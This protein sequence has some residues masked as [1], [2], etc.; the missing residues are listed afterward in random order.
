ML[1]QQLQGAGAVPLVDVEAVD[2]LD[3]WGQLPGMAEQHR[4]DGAAFRGGRS[5]T[6]SQVAINQSKV[7]TAAQTALIKVA[8]A[9]A[10]PPKDEPK[11]AE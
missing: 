4:G 1:D 11:G 7:Q 9:N 6:Q 5:K 10:M 8:E 2:G 3:A